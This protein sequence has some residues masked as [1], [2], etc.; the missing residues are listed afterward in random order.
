M[1]N[2]NISESPHATGSHVICNLVA[3]QAKIRAFAK[4]R[5]MALGN[6]GYESFYN[7]EEF[8]SHTEILVHFLF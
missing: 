4:F 5:H 8:L 6:Y 3:K 7:G 1:A 2:V